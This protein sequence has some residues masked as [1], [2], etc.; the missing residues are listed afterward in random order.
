[1]APS[2]EGERWAQGP[3]QGS[4]PESGGGLARHAAAEPEWEEVTSPSPCVLAV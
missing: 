4:A 2:G 3:E 1:M